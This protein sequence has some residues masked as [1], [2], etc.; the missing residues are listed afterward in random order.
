MIIIVMMFWHCVLSVAVCNCVALCGCGVQTQFVSIMHQY[1][2]RTPQEEKV[3]ELSEWGWATSA[4]RL[5]GC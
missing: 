4:H 3:L 2:D 5:S 1:R